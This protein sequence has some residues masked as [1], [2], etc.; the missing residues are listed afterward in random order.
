[1][2]MCVICDDE[3]RSPRC[4]TCTRCRAYIHRWGS[5]KDDR[6]ITHFDKL[7]VRVKRMTTFA[8]V[9]DE[10]VKYVDFNELE[11]RKIIQMSKRER[12]MRAK[13]TATV[14]SIRTAEKQ[15]SRAVFPE[16]QRRPA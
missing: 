4:V 1:M 7:R 11:Q 5:E 2:E 9:Q 6:I 3:E 12:R 13:S 16:Q 10:N 15:K 14:I 8:I